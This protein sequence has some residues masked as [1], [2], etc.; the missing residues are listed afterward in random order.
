MDDVKEGIVGVITNHSWLDNP[1]FRG[2]RQSLMRSFQ[3]IYVLDLHGNVKKK[4]RT[5]D[6][7]KDE[8]VFDIEQ[9]V[10]ISLFVK[11][12]GLKRGIWRCDL[13]GRRLEKYSAVNE[14]NIKD[15]KQYLEPTPPFYMFTPQNTA[16]GEKYHR[17]W[18]LSNIALTNVLGFQ[19]H[20]DAFAVSFTEQEMNQKISD[21]SDI[22]VTDGE[23]TRLY[24]LKSNRDWSFSDARIDA[25]NGKATPPQ[26][27]A[28]RPLDNRWSEFSRLT[29]DYPRR[30]LLQ[31]VSGRSNICLLT[32][33]QIGTSD[34]RHVFVANTPA[35]S[36]LVSSD[37]KSQNYVF[38][39]WLYDENNNTRENVSDNFRTFLNSSYS[40]HYSAEEI[41]GYI[42]AILNAREYRSLYAEFLRI[43]FP[44]IPFPGS[45]SDFEH[46]SDLGWALVEVHLLR[47]LTRR[48]LANYPAQGNHRV[49]AVRYAPE[50]EAIHI[51]KMQYFKRCLKPSGSSM[52]AAI[53]CS[54]NI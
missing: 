43:D 2:M 24:G 6:G 9:G 8:N 1:T 41:F 44:R 28:Y 30:Q 4:E 7:S 52:W 35:E 46:L 45:A 25:R 10:A 37:T 48:G 11:R 39:M 18:K 20:R 16:L 29:I 34:W 47:S 31:H 36:C 51:N 19:T 26:I 15:V 50:Q 22:N 40:H 53:R 42:Y 5:P 27:V 12:R 17:F 33:R 54:T 23:L 21:L 32:T 13:W 3:Q 38:P 49:E 14:Q